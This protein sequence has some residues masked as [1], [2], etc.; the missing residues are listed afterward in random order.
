LVGRPSLSLSHRN[1]FQNRPR[2]GDGKLRNHFQSGVLG[3]DPNSA[4]LSAGA[5][6]SIA[7]LETGLYGVSAPEYWDVDGTDSTLVMPNFDSGCNLPAM[8]PDLGQLPVSKLRQNRYDRYACLHHTAAGRLLGL[9]LRVPLS[10]SDGLSQGRDGR[11]SPTIAV[12][13]SGSVDTFG[14]NTQ[15]VN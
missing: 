11:D 2:R 5:H 9:Y 15:I 12:M 1:R 14:M 10:A 8:A 4:I 7:F 13:D 3:A 6:F